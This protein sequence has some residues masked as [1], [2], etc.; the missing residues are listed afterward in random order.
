MAEL[1]KH[2]LDLTRGGIGS[3]EGLRV[4]AEGFPMLRIVFEPPVQRLDNRCVCG[5]E[6]AAPVPEEE[7]SVALFLTRKDL[8]DDH[9]RLGGQCFLN[10][11]TARLSDEDMVGAQHFRD[12]FHPA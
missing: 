7:F 6:S 5:A 1:G 10:R 2:P 11:C 4:L 3:S 8:S 9:R 12:V